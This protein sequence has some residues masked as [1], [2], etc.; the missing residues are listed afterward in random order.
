[1]REVNEPLQKH[2]CITLLENLAAEPVLRVRSGESNLESAFQDS[3]DLR[4]PRV[5]VRWDHSLRSIVGVS[6]GNAN[7]V[8]SRE[9]PNKDRGHSRENCI[10][11]VLCCMEPAERKVAGM[12]LLGVNAC[13]AIYSS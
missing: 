7:G 4:G 8:Q 6:H 10:S 12:G 3:N 9:L 1:M 11:R 5:G 13:E 2:E